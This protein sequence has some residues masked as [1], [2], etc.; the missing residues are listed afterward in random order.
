ML[1]DIDMKVWRLSNQKPPQ[2]GLQVG[3]LKKW[4]Y[5]SRQPRL[6]MMSK[7]R[8]FVRH[9]FE[10]AAAEVHVASFA[11]SRRY[12]RRKSRMQA[13]WSSAG[14]ATQK[15]NPLP[16][17]SFI[18]F[19][20]CFVFRTARATCRFTSNAVVFLLN[21]HRLVLFVKGHLQVTTRKFVFTFIRLNVT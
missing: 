12:R 6:A 3:T 20:S 15:G 17:S 7:R 11:V 10:R 8:R 14:G 18:R 21:T 2:I 19:S 13:M 16:Y 4:R 9:V 1:Y 5:L